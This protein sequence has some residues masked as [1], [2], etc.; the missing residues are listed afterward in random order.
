M[1]VITTQH[2]LTPCGLRN[3]NEIKDMNAKLQFQRETLGDKDGE[4]N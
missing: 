3:V 2:F 4:C 1:F